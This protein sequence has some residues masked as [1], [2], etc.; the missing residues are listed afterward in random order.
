MMRMRLVII[1]M[2]P[3]AM[4]AHPQRGIPGSVGGG[5]AG[6]GAGSV[7]KLKVADQSLGMF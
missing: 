1:L 5:A 3:M 4:M 2:A 6:A 7:T